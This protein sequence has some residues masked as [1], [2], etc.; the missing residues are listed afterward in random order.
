MKRVTAFF[1]GLLF[2]AG[3]LLGGMTQPSKVNGF[4]DVM[5]TWN[6]SLMF[7]MVGGIATHGALFR[8]VTRRP[9]PLLEPR[10]MIPTRKDIDAPL[11]VGAALFG[12]GWGLGGFCPGPGLVSVTQGGNALTFVGAMMLGMRLHSLRAR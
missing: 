10:F 2:G 9:S 1:A 6:P 5:G 7:V 3:L 12:V 11:I 4:L 8:W